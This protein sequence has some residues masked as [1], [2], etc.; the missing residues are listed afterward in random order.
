MTLIAGLVFA[1]SMWFYVQHVLVPHQRSEAVL[2]ATPRGNLSD[3]YPRWLGA[4]ELLLHHRDP[5]SQAITSEIQVGYYGRELNPARPEDPKDQ[6][7]FAYPV[8]VV[9]LLAP[10][11]TAPFA[12]VQEVFRWFLFVLTVAAPLLW[13]RAL[14][15]RPSPV[16]EALLVALTVCSFPGLQGLKLQQLSL[17]VSAMLAGVAVLAV[18]SH[19]LLAGILLALATIKPQLAVLPAA[20]LLFWTFS[21]WRERQ[22]FFWGFA[23]TLALLIGGG[24]WLLPGWIGRFYEATV[25]Y[26]HYTGGSSLLAVLAGQA[27]GVVFSAL[28]LLALAWVGW[29][30]RRASSSSP[31]FIVVFALTLA[32]T[33]LVIPMTAP[34]NQIL[35]LPAVLLIVRSREALWQRSVTVR[36]VFVVAV[37]L[38]L[39]PWVATAGLMIAALFVP[40]ESLQLAWP[41]PLYTSLEIPLAIAGLLGFLTVEAGGQGKQET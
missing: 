12:V 37:T 13:L 25:A 40:S 24:Q 21:A 39:W 19:L 4:R 36:L 27:A 22:R 3:L 5:Y 11:I 34:Y 38:F 15:W 10:T 35:L 1:V 9:F 18:G 29:N 16:A 26:Q 8:Y 32:V 41:I 23:A 7:G 28:A 33:L 6:Q 20:W 31:E 2:R 30:S 14:R 17:V